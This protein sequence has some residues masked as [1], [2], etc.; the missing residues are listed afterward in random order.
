MY[1]D[2]PAGKTE[3]WSLQR[4]WSLCNAGE[5]FHGKMSSFE[6]TSGLHRKE[7]GLYIKM[8]ARTDLTVHKYQYSVRMLC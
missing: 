3:K 1:K 6:F 7:G 2:R 8:V 5:N 4:S